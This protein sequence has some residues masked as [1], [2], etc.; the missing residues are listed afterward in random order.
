M[1]V[2]AFLRRSLGWTA[3]ALA[4]GALVGPALGW[5]ESPVQPLGFVLG[6]GSFVAFHFWVLVTSIVLILRAG[7]PGE[8]RDLDARYTTPYGP[9]VGGGASG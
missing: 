7:A 9:H 2:I 1:N 3:A 8:V 4:L 5:F 6:Y